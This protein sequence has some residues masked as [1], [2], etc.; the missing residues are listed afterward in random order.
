MTDETIAFRCENTEIHLTTRCAGLLEVPEFKQRGPR[1]RIELVHRTARDFTES[2][3]SWLEILHNTSGTYFNSDVSILRASVLRLGV[4]CSMQ[5]TPSKDVS[6][7]EYCVLFHA[8]ILEVNLRG[9]QHRNETAILGDMAKLRIWRGNLNTT[10]STRRLATGLLGSLRIRTSQKTGNLSHLQRY[11]ASLLTWVRNLRNKVP[12]S[13]WE[14]RFHVPPVRPE[15]VSLLLSHHANLHL[16]FGKHP[17]LAWANTNHIYSF[18]NT[19]CKLLWC[20]ARAE[21]RP[22][23]H[24]QR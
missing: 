10:K 20:S 6:D 4:R 1:A 9:T 17:S 13:K 18:E 2:E 11:L 3:Q 19:I 8:R 23:I 7:L 5:D 21:S 24:G 15:M 12:R 16:K 14:D 22:L